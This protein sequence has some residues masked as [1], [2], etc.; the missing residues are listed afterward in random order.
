MK[1]MIKILDKYWKAKHPILSIFINLQ[2]AL[3]AIFLF[4]ILNP[5]ILNIKSDDIFLYIMCILFYSVSIS[6]L[7]SLLR[8]IFFYLL[9][10]KYE[11]KQYVINKYTLESDDNFK[12]NGLN[13]DNMTGEEFE[14]F[15]YK[16]LIKNGYKNVRLTKR[17]GDQGVDIVATKDFVKY[18]IQ[19]KCYN[20]PISNKAVQE[21][22]SG[23]DF[24]NCH[25]AVVMTNQTFTSSAKE[26]A[27]INN[28]LLWDRSILNNLIYNA[29]I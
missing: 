26:L 21:I 3:L 11:L 8:Y 28:V 10:K 1:D 20:Q 2:V 5:F 29:N 15:C 19:C 27:K 9:R 22:Y 17:T 25:V 24:Y 12:K 6:S 7:M 23:K 16:I 18:A 13:Y 4:L 14:I